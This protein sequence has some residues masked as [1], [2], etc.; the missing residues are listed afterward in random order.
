MCREM[1]QNNINDLSDR[2]CNILIDSDESDLKKVRTIANIQLKKNKKVGNE[3]A[4]NI[5]YKYLENMTEYDEKKYRNN[6]SAYYEKI[7]KRYSK[8]EKAL[9]K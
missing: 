3:V 7:S 6:I 5:Y 4:L 2:I 1:P 9:S 8:V